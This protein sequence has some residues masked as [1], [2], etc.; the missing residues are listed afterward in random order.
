MWEVKWEGKDGGKMEEGR[1]SRLGELGK[2]EGLL[3][4]ERIHLFVESES[5]TKVD[6]EGRRVQ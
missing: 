5:E 4:V 3:V 1:T 2:G 6:V